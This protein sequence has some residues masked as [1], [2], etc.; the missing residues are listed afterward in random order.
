MGVVMPRRILI[1]E[2]EPEIRMY[3]RVVL[4]GQ[5]YEVEEAED[6]RVALEKL[7][8]GGFDMMLLDLMLPHVDG[9]E[10]IS[11]LSPEQ[12]EKLPIVIVT[13]CDQDRDIIRGYALG[14]AY[15]ITKPYQN[16]QLI[17]IVTYLFGGM[18]PASTPCL[19][20]PC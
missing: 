4:E 19:S 18:A 11:R 1:T 9:F 16:R 20:R 13:A 12:R 8:Q 3:L 6:G 17:D 7:Q 2:D 14:A 5:G 15:Y 10:V